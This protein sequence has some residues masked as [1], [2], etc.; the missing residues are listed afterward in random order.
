MR[1]ILDACTLIY[2]IKAE[3]FSKFMSLTDFP[4][5]IDSSV[6]KEVVINGKA[7]NYPDASY[8]EVALN[9]FKIPVISID[10]TEELNRFRDAGE[11]SC[12]ILA[13][14][15]GVCLTSDD[16]AYKKFNKE[17]Q[18]VMRLDS[19]YFEKLDQ[20]RLTEAEFIDV[21]KKFEFVNATKPKSFLFFLEKLQKRKEVKN[22]D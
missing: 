3:Q 6:Y 1:W 16:R 7:N 4:V 19:F 21:L 12:Y 9:N 13:Q 15:D 10:I 22:N 8:A 18:K 5:V 2:L 20:K 17:E 14:E 11:T